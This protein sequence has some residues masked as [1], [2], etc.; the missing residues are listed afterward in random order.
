MKRKSIVRK[1]FWS[2]VSIFCVTL[3][4]QLI[5]QM[6]FIEDM[7]LLSKRSDMT[8]AFNSF[9]E[10]YEP[11]FLE[12]D[13]SAFVE[14]K[15]ATILVLDKDNK[16]L[17]G[18][19]FDYMSYVIIRSGG[20]DYKLLLGDR[21]DERGFLYPA[22][23][24]FKVGQT[25]E[26]YGHRM[27]GTNII[28]M[29]T[30]EYKVLWQ[31]EVNLRGEV[32]STHLVAKDNGVFSN[33]NE[34]L[35]REVSLLLLEA[36]HGL[37]NQEGLNVQ[38]EE[39]IEFV[40]TETGLILT[41]L[42]STLEDGNHLY[43]LFTTEDLSNT[44]VVLN[45]YYGILFIL[46]LSILAGLV[47]VFSKWITKP[48]QQLTEESKRIA[49]LDFSSHVELH[50]E[51]ELEDLSDSLGLISKNMATNIQRLENE[52]REKEKSEARM[53]DLLA[54]LSHEFKTPL[55]VM[56]GF[57][58][59]LQDEDANKF[60]CIETIEEEIEKLNQ[61]TKETLL[62]CESESYDSYHLE[63]KHLL[64]DLMSI[65]TF[66]HL[67]EEK[68]IQA[69]IKIDSIHV[70]CDGS[71]IELV[72]NN[73]ISNGIKYSPQ[74]A[75]LIIWSEINGDR[76]KLFIENTGVILDDESLERVWE[77][78]YRGEKSR[79][80]TY[81][82]TGLGLSIVSTILDYHKSDYGVY[83]KEFSVLFYFDLEIIDL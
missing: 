3:L 23:K 19:F 35:L 56:S 50:T 59:M 77:K 55:S 43:S 64:E 6:N 34:K 57:L 27:N 52:A 29:D 24:D 61:L 74:G 12:E 21:V 49:Y 32:I 41:I 7:Y 17:N 42:K 70:L 13:T 20:E 72:L 9:V 30:Y 25:L 47:L 73:L 78:Y 58:E 15:N 38:D 28:I 36:G 8:S 80:K 68:N 71:K 75:K 82:G 4:I 60:Y 46:Q 11:E 18:S 39:L 62:L 22:F 10:E 16:I 53:R 37:K 5:I 63:E 2:I 40:E 66:R 76:V 67:I 1:I 65:G 81:G 48:I 54:N 14:D 69:D 33:Q 83:N 44:F 45:K 31:E 79:N 26:V 51:D